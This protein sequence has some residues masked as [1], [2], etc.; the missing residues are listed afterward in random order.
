MGKECKIN[1]LIYKGNQNQ[2]F[3][4]SNTK[5]FVLNWF[6]LAHNKSPYLL[7]SWDKK[8]MS[9]INAV[10]DYLLK[11]NDKMS[12]NENSVR[13]LSYQDKRH[14]AEGIVDS[15]EQNKLIESYNRYIS[16]YQNRIETLKNIKTDIVFKDIDAMIEHA[17]STSATIFNEYNEGVRR[18]LG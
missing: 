18:D 16:T 6:S 3:S 11:N 10:S 9:D 15:L 8:S 2:E 7:Q 13:K 4:Y 14:I 5:Y 17:K 1:E 12:N